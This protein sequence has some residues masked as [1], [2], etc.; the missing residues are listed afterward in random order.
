MYFI[1][2]VII[3]HKFYRCFKQLQKEQLNSL[4]TLTCSLKIPVGEGT[5]NVPKGSTPELC[6]S[7]PC[8]CASPCVCETDGHDAFSDSVLEQ[9]FNSEADLFESDSDDI[10]WTQVAEK[11]DVHVTDSEESMNSRLGYVE[12]TG[13]GSEH[14]KIAESILNPGHHHQNSRPNVGMHSRSKTTGE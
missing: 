14:N 11:M 3:A 8:G 2:Y 13:A 12:N 10:F 9:L 1:L 5:L 4:H 6:S 7:S